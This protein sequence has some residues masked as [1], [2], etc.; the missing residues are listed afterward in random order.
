MIP[1]SQDDRKKTLMKEKRTSTATPLLLPF[2]AVVA[3]D[4]PYLPENDYYWK[5][6]VPCKLTTL[7]YYADFWSSKYEEEIPS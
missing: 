2:Q 7:T 4:G 6:S 5:K 1:E 3:H